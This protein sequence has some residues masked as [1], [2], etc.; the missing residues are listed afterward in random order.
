LKRL[1]LAQ[2]ISLQKPLHRPL[3]V[4][5]LVLSGGGGNIVTVN[6]PQTDITGCTYGDTNG[7]VSLSMPYLALPTTAGNDEVSVV[8]T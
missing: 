4:P 5:R 7:V 6:A 3:A 8:F 1:Q 2:P